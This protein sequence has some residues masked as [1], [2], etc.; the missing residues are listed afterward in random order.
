MRGT[1]TSV[2]AAMFGLYGLRTYGQTK[3]YTDYPSV[4]WS[5][6]DTSRTQKAFDGLVADMCGDKVEM[7]KLE[8]H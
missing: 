5:K 1:R 6:A 2:L 8:G 3:C 7:K 4:G